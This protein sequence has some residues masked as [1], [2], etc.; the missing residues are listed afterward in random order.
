MK[1]LFTGGEPLLYEPLLEMTHFAKKIGFICEINTNGYYLDKFDYSEI[2]SLYAS[3]NISIH[4]NLA[5]EHD[6][7]VGVH[8]AWE[9]VVASIL[10]LRKHNANIFIITVLTDQ[11]V[12]RF[13]DMKKFVEEFLD[14]RWVPDVNI[15]PTYEKS[16]DSVNRYTVQIESL[17]NIIREKEYREIILGEEN[18]VLCT[19]ECKA[20]R[21]LCFIDS[22]GYVYPCLSFKIDENERMIMKYPSAE[23]QAENDI[24]HFITWLIEKKILIRE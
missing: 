12:S 17:E 22:Q 15:S 1:V 14:C 16:Y 9:R 5:E 21:N 7:M 8:G 19:G 6:K 3:I 4:S 2:A 23:Q 24:S 10:E 11:E 20:A 18:D 13:K